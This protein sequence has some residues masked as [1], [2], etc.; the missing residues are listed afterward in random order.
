M[1]PYQ[2][3][4]DMILSVSFEDDVQRP[5]QKFEQA[6]RTSKGRRLAAAL[7]CM[8]RSVSTSPRTSRSCWRMRRRLQEVEAARH[9]HR[10]GRPASSPSRSKVSIHDIGTILDREGIAIRTSHHCAQPL[11]MP[12]TYPPPAGPPSAC[13]TRRPGRREIAGLHN[14]IGYSANHVRSSRA[15]PG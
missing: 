8:P 11:M 9:R 6:R 2:G 1:P 5:S 15:V 7:D 13:T 14:V 4:G 12:S 3:G 10:S